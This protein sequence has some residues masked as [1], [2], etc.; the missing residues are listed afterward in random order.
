MRCECLYQGNIEQAPNLAFG[1]LKA[2]QGVCGILGS[3][4]TAPKARGRGI[5]A[6]A[7]RHWLVA[8]RFH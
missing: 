4:D 2:N 5:L 8:V 1:R 6:L 3:L 7:I